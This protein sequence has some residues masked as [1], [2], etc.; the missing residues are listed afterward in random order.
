M[1]NREDIFKIVK[2]YFKEN[3][4]E[5]PPN[6]VPIS[7][8]IFDEEE[9]IAIVDAALD[10]WWT[11]SRYNKKFEKLL[12]DFIGVKYCTTLNSG[13]SAN[14]IA[15]LTFT[16][17]LIPENKRLMPRDEVI[18]IASAFP[19]TI[20]PIIQ[21]GAVPVFVDLELE[22][23]NINVNL[24]EDAISD[25]TKVIFVAHTLGNP[26]DLGK[27]V[28][29]GKKHDL[30]IIEDNCDALG[31]E[32]DGQRTGSFGDL[33][34]LSFYPAHHITTAEGGAI[35]TNNKL[36]KKIVISLRDWGRDCWCGTGMDNSCGKRF[37]W[38][39]GDLPYGY[40]HK[41]IYSH[42]GYNLKLTDL[43]AAIGV[44]QMKKLDSFIVRRRKNFDYL[45]KR[46][47]EEKLNDYFILPKAIEKANPSWFGFLVT[48]KS[49][50]IERA[51]LLEFLNK[52]YVATR[53]VFGGNIIKQPYFQNYNVKYRTVGTLEN[54]DRIMNDAFW[55]GLY[56]GLDEKRLE[57]TISTIKKYIETLN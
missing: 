54:T 6:K 43:Q 52:H 55:L 25:K 28:E 21:S 15:L 48:I 37:S 49:D 29:I 51:K 42:I 45:T 39:L 40:D 17:H 22:T 35:L 36:L 47:L 53:L 16:S 38:K 8:K 13:S 50:K 14:L 18:T 30:W 12:S 27:I 46:F 57:I 20:N 24:I 32:F 26:F 7:G 34:T 2:Q 11:E 23:C 44:A 31:S 5:I 4:N 19:T 9:M 3:K 1:V 33:S 41:Y 10:G 56:P